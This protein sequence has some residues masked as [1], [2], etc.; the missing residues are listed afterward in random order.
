MTGRAI[1]HPEEID[2]HHR[3]IADDPGVVAAGQ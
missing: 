2:D 3:F 1:T